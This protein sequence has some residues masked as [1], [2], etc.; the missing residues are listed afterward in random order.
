MLAEKHPEV[1]KAVSCAYK[2]TFRERW[3]HTLLDWQIRRMDE[4]GFQQQWKEEGQTEEK[5]KIAQNLLTKG[6]TPDFIH[7]ITGLDLETIQKLRS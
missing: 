6:S 2:I 1:K 7:E 3:R 5:L 4:R